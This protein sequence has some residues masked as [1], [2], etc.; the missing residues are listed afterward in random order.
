MAKLLLWECRNHRSERFC[1]TIY[2]NAE[3]KLRSFGTFSKRVH[4]NHF[5][6]DKQ[7][8][9]NTAKKLVSEAETAKAIDLVEEFLKKDARYKILLREATHLSS[10]FVKTQKDEEKGIISFENAKLSYSQ[11]NDQLLNLLDYIETD[12]LKPEALNK[13]P[14][15]WRGMYQSNRLL[16]LIGA[17]LVVISIAVLIIL[18]RL[19]DTD[20]DVGMQNYELCDVN[21]SPGAENILVLP[22]FRPGGDEI[23]PEGLIVERL[24]DFSNRLQL[25]SSIELCENFKP[26]YLLDY[27]EADKKGRD[28]QAKLIIWGRA[29]KGGGSTVIKTRF[30]YL[31]AN[32]TLQFNRLRWQGEKQIV[33][34]KVLSIITAEG[35]LTNDVE[36]ALMLALGLVAGQ[37][38]NRDAAITALESAQVKDSA[39]IL[40]KNMM[41]ADNFIET[42]Q[43]D[44]AM[45]ALD[46]L[47]QT[48]PNYWLG[49]SNRAMLSME[50]GDY[51]GA[52][53]DLTVAL[54][55][56][57]D[58]PELLLTRGKALLKS[59]QLYPAREDFEK[60]IQKNPDR[61]P[62]VKEDLK[63]TNKRILAN[64]TILRQINTKPSNDLTRRDYIAAADASRQLGDTKS[65]RQFVTK[66]LEV[67]K[68]NPKLI[69]IQIDNLLREKKEAE[70][71]Q[72][73]KDAVKRGVRKEEIVKHSPVVKKFTEREVLEK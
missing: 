15:G 67:E 14:E 45:A 1:E 29:E 27:P 6:M 64:E 62:E 40:M 20:G 24:Q 73:L 70:A 18:L 52:V 55:K 43:P 50:S 12:N 49:R 58:D 31:G 19:N 56:R 48:H 53:E 59:E 51:L 60:F 39:A 7:T 17:P 71:S 47:L 46:T 44:K 66:G 8:L 13:M 10:Q 57:P 34:D 16:F 36:A 11:V 72:V 54:Q 5:I 21:F 33:T 4:S 69:A 28:N 25:T 68:N 41:L 35:E 22:F 32:D 26:K 23:Q 38:G 2:K 3:N 65:T 9:L 30:K 37:S 61:A 42:K 63:E